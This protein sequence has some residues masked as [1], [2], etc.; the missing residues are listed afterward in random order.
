MSKRTPSVNTI[1][2]SGN[3]VRDPEVKEVGDNK[4]KVTTFTIANN[5]PYQD[6][7]NNW[8]EE[9][10]FVDIEAWGNLAKKIENRTEKGS[11]LLVEGSLKLNQWENNDGKTVSKILIRAD[12]IHVL[13]HEKKKE[14]KF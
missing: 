6:K 13:E 4:L 12:R 10:T 1:I 11:P 8:Q 3:V 9:T 14:E 5:R 7:D 2:I